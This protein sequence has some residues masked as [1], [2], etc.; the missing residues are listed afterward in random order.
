MKLNDLRRELA[1]R[2]LPT[3][4]LKQ[5][6]AWRLANLGDAHDVSPLDSLDQPSAPLSVAK[7][8]ECTP[9]KTED[10]NLEATEMGEKNQEQLPPIQPDNSLPSVHDHNHGDETRLT[11]GFTR[12]LIAFLSIL[13]IIFLSGILWC[14]TPTAS[15]DHMGRILESGHHLVSSKFTGYQT[16]TRSQIQQIHYLVSMKIQL[17]RATV[18]QVR[19]SNHPPRIHCCTGNS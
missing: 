5:D 6:L 11:S 14:Y 7:N 10:G 1:L 4:G 13:L 16:L 18:Q 9:A 3:E 15:K 2:N 17:L 19:N 8:E 12:I